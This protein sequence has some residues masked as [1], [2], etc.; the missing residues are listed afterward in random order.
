MSTMNTLERILHR[1]PAYEMVDAYLLKYQNGDDVYHHLMFNGKKFKDEIEL[2]LSNGD[3]EDLKDYFP[4]AIG[5]RKTGT[6]SID[7]LSLI[8]RK[9]ALDSIIAEQSQ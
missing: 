1:L 8:Y 4:E 9:L 7:D 5:L 6:V 2:P 3:Y